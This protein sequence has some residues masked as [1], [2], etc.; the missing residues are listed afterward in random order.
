MGPIRYRFV[1]FYNYGR[2]FKGVFGESGSSGIAL[3]IEDGITSI[4]SEAF[5][6]NQLTSVVIPNSVTSIGY[7]AFLNNKLASVVI[8][9]SVTSIER[10]GVL[11]Q[12]TGFGRD[13]PL[14]DLN[15]G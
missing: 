12:P 7:R 13:S 6:D 1:N 8:P 3:V 14:G 11:W 9:S 10:G 2:T 15:W 5:M 4:E